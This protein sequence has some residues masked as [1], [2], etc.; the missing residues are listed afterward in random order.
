MSTQDHHQSPHH[1]DFSNY[2][3]HNHNHHQQQPQPQHRQSQP[4]GLIS[5]PQSSLLPHFEDENDDLENTS[6]SSSPHQLRQPEQTSFRGDEEK[7]LDIPTLQ[8]PTLT[9]TISQESRD[10]RDREKEKLQ[11]DG[12]NSSSSSSSNNNSI[13][14]SKQNKGGNM[15]PNVFKNIFKDK[16]TSNQNQIKPISESDKQQQQ[17]QQQNVDEVENFQHSP[18]ITSERLKISKSN[19]EERTDD[20]NNNEDKNMSVHSFHSDEG[21]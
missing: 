13:N 18:S 4:K 6:P 19:L 15:I 9:T 14:N 20:N 21:S 11:I 17:Q 5:S 10:G 8:N 1:L 16:K 3:N 12:K 2:H 7:I